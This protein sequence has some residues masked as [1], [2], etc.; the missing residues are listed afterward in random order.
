MALFA[1]FISIVSPSATSKVR[2]STDIEASLLRVRIESETVLVSG[3][4][5]LRKVRL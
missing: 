2:L 1:N 4:T 5:T 3:I